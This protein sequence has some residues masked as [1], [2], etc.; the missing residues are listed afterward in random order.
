MSLNNMYSHPF[1]CQSF[2]HLPLIIYY[3]IVQT[4]EPFYKR[5]AVE[6]PLKVEFPLQIEPEKA[7]KPLSVT[8][9]ERAVMRAGGGGRKRGKEV[10]FHNKVYPFSVNNLPL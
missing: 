2:T 6:F 10:H 3:Q 4:L 5:M 1:F 7:E 9:G 8:M